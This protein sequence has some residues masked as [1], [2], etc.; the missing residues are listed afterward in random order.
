MSHMRTHIH[1]WGGGGGRHQ[2]FHN[3]IVEPLNR[4]TRNE[5]SN[6]KKSYAEN[7]IGRWERGVGAVRL[8]VKFN[9]DV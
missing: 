5:E 7:G 9:F 1:K 6:N 3:L 4:A 2:A 8:P